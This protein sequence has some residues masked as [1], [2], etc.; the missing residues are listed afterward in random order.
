MCGGLVLPD[1]GIDLLDIEGGADTLA[2][3]RVLAKYTQVCGIEFSLGE[4]RLT[5]EQVFQPESILP[6][7]SVEAMRIW[8]SLETRPNL[9]PAAEDTLGIEFD[10]SRDGFFP[11]ASYP[12]LVGTDLTSTL[13]LLVYVLAARRVL[14][15]KEGM[16]ID[17]APYISK[18]DQIDWEGESLPNI[19]I[20]EGFDLQFQHKEF[21]T[22]KVAQQADEPTTTEMLEVA[23]PFAS[24]QA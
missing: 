19:P 8:Q 20:P 10:I 13:R 23:N 9:P 12:P 11:L 21:M 3:H 5:Q 7:I 6:V 24:Q 14:G 18:W 4:H 22:Q 16:K 17:L 1:L 15:L 2:I